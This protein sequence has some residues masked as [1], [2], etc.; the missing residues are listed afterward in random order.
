MER[1]TGMPVSLAGT[2]GAPHIRHALFAS[3]HRGTSEPDDELTCARFLFGSELSRDTFPRAAEG[4]TVN[5]YDDR[6]ADRP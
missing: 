6:D 2:T 4:K 5:E 3:V 1:L